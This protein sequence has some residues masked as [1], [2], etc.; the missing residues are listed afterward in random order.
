MMP[1]DDIEDYYLKRGEEKAARRRA[2]LETK[3]A[4]QAA[5]EAK[6]GEAVDK[7]I[8]RVWKS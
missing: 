4:A 7:A 1:K 2:D 8:G 5:E 6:R 3:E